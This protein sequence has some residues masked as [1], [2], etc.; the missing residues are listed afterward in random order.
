MCRWGFASHRRIYKGIWQLR[1]NAKAFWQLRV[2]AIGIWQ[3]G[4]AS[5][6][7]SVLLGKAWGS[8]DHN[9]ETPQ[10][11]M[12]IVDSPETKHMQL[13]Y[14]L[15]RLEQASR[16]ACAWCFSRSLIRQ[17]AAKSLDPLLA[18][19]Q[20]HNQERLQKRWKPCS[21][22]HTCLNLNLMAKP[23]EFSPG[24]PA[25]GPQAPHHHT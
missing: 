24:V 6:K 12:S 21:V 13:K 25:S 9:I 5:T 15:F 2:I 17:L 23:P 10:T 3:S 22:T 4:V 7:L 16:N 14:E 1:V 8:S 20:A 11:K 19:L 18:C